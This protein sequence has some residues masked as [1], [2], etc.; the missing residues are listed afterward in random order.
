VLVAVV[1]TVNGW[2]DK[3]VTAA[4][5]VAPTYVKVTLVSAES[6]PDGE[7]YGEPVA[8]LVPTQSGGSVLRP[9]KPA[10]SKMVNPSP[11]VTPAGGGGGGPPHISPCSSATEYVMDT[12]GSNETTM[13]VSVNAFAVAPIVR[14]RTPIARKSLKFIGEIRLTLSRLASRRP[15]GGSAS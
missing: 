1:S 4:S 11:T 9:T 6:V 3:L 15:V 10:I 13:G 14:V 5:T 7:P 12:P 8:A 2:N